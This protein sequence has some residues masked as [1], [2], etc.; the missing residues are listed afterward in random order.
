[1][2]F[3][4]NPLKVYLVDDEPLALK[5]LTKLLLQTGSVEIVG[6]TSKPLEAFESIPRLTLDALF[7]DIQMPEL[8][9]FELLQNLN[10]Y[11]PV[12]FTTAFDEFALDA[13][14]VF[15]IDYL[16]KP[17][18]PKRLE[19]ALHKLEK[20]KAEKSEEQMVNLQKLLESLQPKPILN[21]FPSKIGGKVQIHNVHEIP[22]FFSKDKL[23][24]AQ[25]AEGRNLPVSFTLSELE[26]RLDKTAFFRLSRNLIVNIDFIDEVKFT[27]RV[28]MRLKNLKKT[29]LNVTRE[30]VKSLKE[31]L[32]L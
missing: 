29:E 6:Q 3:M 12:I 10:I 19:Q 22:I 26:N 2:I 1:M 14:E 18:S 16:L 24:F 21:R 30:R 17:I 5:R 7:L 9:G 4:K 20:L 11:P 27:G 8:N 31:F 28:F 32:G 23:T 25:N 13:F 15:S